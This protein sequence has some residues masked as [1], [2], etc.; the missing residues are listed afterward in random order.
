MVKNIVKDVKFLSLPSTDM[1]EDD[2]YIIADLK[3]T[4]LFNKRYCVGMA[5]NMIGYLKNAIIFEDN[6]KVYNVLLNPKIIKSE[7]EYEIEEGC[8]SLEGKRKTTRYKK[9][10]VEYLDEFYRKRIKT[11]TDFEAEIIQHEIDH[12][13]GILI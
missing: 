9:I 10:K 4:L 13:S 7:G 8:L 1:T 3:D 6:K 2:K 5:A 12:L 11:F